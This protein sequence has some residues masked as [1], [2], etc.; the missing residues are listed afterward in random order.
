M[1]RSVAVFLLLS[2][3]AL[4]GRSQSVVRYQADLDLL[5]EQLQTTPSFKDQIRNTRK[6]SF[7]SLYQALR[8]DTAQAGN[9]F[10]EFR[11]LSKLFFQLKDNHLGFY[12]QPEAVLPLTEYQNTAAIEKYRQSRFFTQF[13]AVQLSLDSLQQALS[14][15]PADSIEGIYHYDTVL[16]IGLYRTAQPGELIG[17]V[18]RSS[19]PVWK[20]GQVAA[21]LY[22]Q[23][24]GTYRALYAHPFYKYFQFYTT[25]KAR[26]Q[27]LVNSWFYAS[28]SNAIYKKKP[29]APDYVNIP[30]TTP[31]LQFST[32]N[33]STQYLR[34]GTF[35]SSD[36]DLKISQAFFDRIK[37]SLTA[38]HLIVD[39]RNNNGGGYKAA[40]KFLQLLKR[41]SSKGKIYLLIN[42]G[43]M[44]YGE[45]FTLQLRKAIQVTV[46]G[47]T[48]Q[49]TIAYGVNGES[50]LKF[51]SRRFA[52]T[53]TD[54]KDVGYSPYENIGVAPDHE[55]DNSADW[56]QKLVD[57]IGQ[58]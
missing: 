9:S 55:W 56:I 53:M 25:E 31:R 18:L 50:S 17:V 37:D 49:G 40:G 46:Y 57:I 44:S 13:P 26:N 33:A 3:I 4:P 43:T 20:P 10:A 8:S 11:Q 23:E 48:T 51:P 5:Y 16:S 27:S 47:Q 24:P 39:L 15:T 32:L 22:E 7:D 29:L 12:Q 45:I 28:P 21:Y 36:E 19:L 1:I 6:A 58:Q 52:G 35:Q 14:T 42:Y 41:Y 38:P 2:M 30:R 54:M 34:L